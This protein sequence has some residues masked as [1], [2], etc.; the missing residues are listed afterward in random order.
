MDCLSYLAPFFQ[1]PLPP[2]SVTLNLNNSVYVTDYG[3]DK[4]QTVI[5]RVTHNTTNKSIFFH[6]NGD[7]LDGTHHLQID[8]TVRVLR[9]DNC[10][11]P[12]SSPQDKCDELILV[13]RTVPAVNNSRIFCRARS[14]DANSNMG[15][16]DSK[17]TV[18][19]VLKDP[20]MYIHEEGGGMCMYVCVY[21]CWLDVHR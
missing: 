19:I 15:K 3:Q 5:C 20:G 18:T 1:P 13:V 17:E 7:E 11:D 14:R 6:L 9:F 12:P 16:I 10:F 4:V 2:D 8:K 21:V